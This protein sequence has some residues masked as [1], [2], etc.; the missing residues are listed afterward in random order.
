MPINVINLTKHKN[1]TRMDKQ[2]PHCVV[3]TC[4]DEHQPGFLDFSYRIAALASE[5]QLS[6]LSKKA[7]NQPE[8]MLSDA[9]YYVIDTGDGKLGW[10]RYLMK[11]VA[12]INKLSP[13][14]VVL[15]HS[16]LSPISVF[17]RNIPTCLYWNEH[18]T[19]LMHVGI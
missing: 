1:L 8:L 18:P 2:K 13:A 14:I 9:S 16:A 12:M 5:Y 6:I 17:V 19:N 15:L 11:S 7:L 10:V 4:F 3:V